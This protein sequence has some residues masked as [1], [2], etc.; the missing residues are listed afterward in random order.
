MISAMSNS[1]ARKP[2]KAARPA[3]RSA[4]PARPA[5]STPRATAGE[6]GLPLAAIYQGESGLTDFFD[7][8]PIGMLWADQSGRILRINRAL[9]LL[10][11]CRP[12][13][14]VGFRL[15]DLFADPSV[16]ADL[17]RQ[18]RRGTPVH[19]IR[20][21][22]KRN[23]DGL[24]HVLIDANVMHE[25]GATVHSR[26]FIRDISQR[27]ELEK[28]LLA[29]SEREQRRIGQDLHD[30]LCQE[31]TCIEYLCQA[32]HQK[33]KGGAAS[34]AG[35]AAEIGTM[36]R[37]AIHQ[38]RELARGLF[39]V[40]LEA[41]GLMRALQRLVARTNGLY[42]VECRF[43]CPAPVLIHDNTLGINLFRIAQEAVGNAIRHGGARRIEL[44]LVT[45]NRRI[46]L[47]IKDDGRGLPKD[48]RKGRG[49]GLQIMQYRTGMMNGI[50]SVDSQPG[51]GVTVSCS[52]PETS[53]KPSKPIDQP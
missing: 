50:W 44:L 16:L 4:R 13:D 31:L 14:R 53:F 9:S 2:P 41:D 8:A 36:L 51:V 49:M 24:L 17:V 38:T 29:V 34:E 28:E 22:L 15:A 5:R 25:N 12:E 45:R 30:D 27:V 43:A 35:R 23:G 11:D 40:D 33:L 20:S 39:P 10:L 52:V 6:A 21:R 32:L 7:H 46:Q 37:Q 26:W 47:Q 42:Q 18:L 3:R 1:P 19:D 48:M